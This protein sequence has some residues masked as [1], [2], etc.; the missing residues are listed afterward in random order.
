MA[1]EAAAAEA[2]CA[3]E[4]PAEPEEASRAL[5]LLM[6]AAAVL[7]LERAAKG[8]EATAAGLASRP[9]A[10]PEAK[11]FRAAGSLALAPEMGGEMATV[12]S[13]APTA[14]SSS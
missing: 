2:I 1:A 5:A 10:S 7:M 12:K 11:E 13:A 14:P 6:R 9:A 4:E 3:G 8:L